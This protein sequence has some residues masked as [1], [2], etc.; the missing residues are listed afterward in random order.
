MASRTF[1]FRTALL[2]SAALAVSAGAAPAWAQASTGAAADTADAADAAELGEVVVTARRT[3]ERAQDVPIPL[4]VVSGTQL[5]RSGGYTLVDIQNRTPNLVAFNTNPRNS[6]VGI[7]GIGVSSASDG[8][9]T[10]VGVYVDGVYLGRPGMALSDLVDIDQVEVLRGPQG[11]LFGRNSSA[12]VLN[13]TTRKPTFTPEGTI[14]GSFGDYSYVQLRG[15]LSGP[16]INGLLAG[17]IT[18]FRTDRDGVLDNRTTHLRGNSIG[19][20]GVRLQLLATPTPKLT[21]RLIAEYGDENDTCCVSIVDQVFA[22]TLSA[23]TAR[24]LNAFAALG[25]RPVA[26]RDYSLGNAPQRMR[27]EQKAIS[28]QVDYDLGF[29]DLT[30]ITAWR[31]WHFDPLQDSDS[32]PLDIIQ[33]NAAI[34]RDWQYSQEVRLGSKP[35]RFTWQTGIYLFEQRLKDHYILNQFGTDA[36]AFYTTYNRL[37]NAAAP[38]VSIA[39]GSQY[40]GDTRAVTESAAAFGQVNYELTDRLTVTG[41]LRYTHDK[42]HGITVT[43]NRGTPLASTSIPFNYD[44]TVKGGNWSYLASATYKVTPHANLYASYSTGY[45]AAGLNLN[46]SVTAGSPLVVRPE[47]VKDGE[48]GLKSTFW[49]GK[50]LLNANVY[51]SD[52]TGLQANIAPPNGAKSYLANVGD[53]RA[54]GVEAEGE[55]EATEHLTLSVNGSYNDAHYTRY[56]NAPCPVG[57]AAPCDLTGR[58]VYQAPKWV[59]NAQARYETELGNRVR[60][61]A[62]LQYSYRSGVFGSV[63]DAA[64]ARIKGYSLVN[65]RIGARFNERYE[66]SIWVNNLLD[67]DYLQTLGSASIPGA[68]AWGT[69]GQ[70]GAPQ[71]WGV[72][73]R[74]EF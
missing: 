2:A 19:R 29:A 47:K 36:S 38:A 3:E 61:F 17:R 4:S 68:G 21:A 42:R 71:T 53:I 65:A 44:V 12:G 69:T 18:A 22:P 50:V 39:P 14:E 40:I 1:P 27:T 26:D 45:K 49:N 23:T 46:A 13:I 37:S 15:S 43:S 73:L 7:R 55:W 28:A 34:T 63:D 5:E 33:K 66:A 9:D 20:S 41:G 31:E 70:L 35:G 30:S 8:L 64:Y 51:W 74:A 11:T 62:L 24:T 59:A 6:S 32:T 58:P 54:R 56:A 52:L 10:S 25:Y 48:F 72:T 67:E 16:I 57:V 60:P